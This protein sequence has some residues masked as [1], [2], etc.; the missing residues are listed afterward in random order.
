MPNVDLVW[1]A[2]RRLLEWI[3]HQHEMAKQDRRITRSEK[4]R[5]RTILGNI[6]VKIYNQI[7]Q[8]HTLDNG[9]K[10]IAVAD[11]FLVAISREFTSDTPSVLSPPPTPASE[12]ELVISETLLSLSGIR[13]SLLG[14]FTR[15]DRAQTTMRFSPD[16]YHT[17]F[18]EI[19]LKYCDPSLNDV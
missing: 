9:G 11:P 16:V 2:T 15:P 3:Q 18:A 5:I 13:S 6:S 17:Q 14:F 12:G 10:L 7:L 19:C 4:I 1:S 8:V